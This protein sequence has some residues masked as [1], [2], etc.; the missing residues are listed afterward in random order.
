MGQPNRTYMYTTQD[1]IAYLRTF[2]AKRTV[3][4]LEK[5]REAYRGRSW[6]GPQMAVDGARVLSEL[7]MLVACAR[8]VAHGA[9]REEMSLGGK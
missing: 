2:A 5:L 8:A 7:N 6:D 1:E 4:D 3:R 9:V